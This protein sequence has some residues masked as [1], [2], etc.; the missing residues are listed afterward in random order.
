MS[1][2]TGLPAVFTASFVGLLGLASIASAAPGDAPP[3]TPENFGGNGSAWVNDFGD[4]Y[5]NQNNPNVRQDWACD[6]RAVPGVGGAHASANSATLDW[7][8]GFDGQG[9][10]VVPGDKSNTCG[11]VGTP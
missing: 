9:T 8:D 5:T 10:L 7:P 11:W 6:Q 3:A 4:H 1:T 2:M